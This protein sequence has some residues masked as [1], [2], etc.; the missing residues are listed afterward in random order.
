MRE[1]LASD[2]ARLTNLLRMSKLGEPRGTALFQW[3]PHPD[4]QAIHDQLAR[5][6]ILVRRF[7]SPP[8]LRFGLPPDETGWARLAHA[9]AAIP[10]T[11]THC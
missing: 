4:A 3:I 2:S 7:D 6:G 8:S 9:L 11:S 1:R 10:H 5:T